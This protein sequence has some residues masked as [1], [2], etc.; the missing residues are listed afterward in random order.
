MTPTS[1]AWAVAL[2]IRACVANAASA[3]VCIRDL[4]MV[5]P[6]SGQNL[7]AAFFRTADDTATDA[8]MM[9]PSTMSC[10]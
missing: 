4:R 9:K 7:K 2:A 3:S 8:M 5:I 10:T 6:L 1:K